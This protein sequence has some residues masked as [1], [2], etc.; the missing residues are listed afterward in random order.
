[1]QAQAQVRSL[2]GDPEEMVGIKGKGLKP[3]RMAETALRSMEVILEECATSIIKSAPGKL[4]TAGDGKQKSALGLVVTEGRVDSTIPG[5]PAQM[6]GIISKDDEVMM[7][8]GSRV[9]SAT[10]GA[11][12]RGDDVIGSVAMLTMRRFATGEVYEVHLPRV[13]VDAVQQRNELDEEMAKL[14]SEAAEAAVSGNRHVLL[15]RFAQLSQAAN[16][17]EMIGFGTIS[18]LSGQVVALRKALDD[19]IAKS[20]AAILDVDATH[21]HVLMMQ[22]MTETELREQISYGQRARDPEEASLA[23]SRN[24]TIGGASQADLMDLSLVHKQVQELEGDLQNL[25][26]ELS[27][28]QMARKELQQDADVL[29]AKLEAAEERIEAFGG[30]Q[31]SMRSMIS[32]LEEQVADARAEVNEYAFC[33]GVKLNCNYDTHAR[34]TVSRGAF[35][36]QL[37][38]DICLALKVPKANIHVMS[39]HRG[40]LIAE[41]KF[42]AV[43]PAGGVGHVRTGRVLATEFVDMFKPGGNCAAIKE[44]S[45]GQHITEVEV[46]N[47]MIAGQALVR[48]RLFA[49]QNC[50]CA[51]L[52]LLD[53]LSFCV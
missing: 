36:A 10:V 40:S 17:V 34:D 25:Q 39:H 51:F 14:R 20:R 44:G 49:L 5:S 48:F 6:C 38:E 9:T 21:Q 31:R 42:N 1:M 16:S 24:M 27:A 13:S 33:A 8:D 52:W 15:D 47:L 18:M 30:G 19:S 2:S 7:V 46:R 35:D 11:A 37:R 32:S 26:D 41:V 22:N 45:V 3:T 12:L 28:S 29:R 4:S 53:S 23:A 43:L 50:I